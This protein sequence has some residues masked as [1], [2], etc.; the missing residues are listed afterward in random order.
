ME[1][2]FFTPAVRLLPPIT[3]PI[4]FIGI[5]YD[6]F[7]ALLKLQKRRVVLSFASWCSS[8]GHTE[9]VAR[10][11]SFTCVGDFSRNGSSSLRE[12]FWRRANSGTRS[13]RGLAACGHRFLNSR[14]PFLS[15]NSI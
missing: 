15:H 3:P 8:P 13:R 7:F 4:L 10:P 14:R 2:I 9:S 12:R 6:Q 5:S 1:N 11:L